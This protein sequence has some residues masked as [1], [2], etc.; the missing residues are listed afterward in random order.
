[1]NDSRILIVAHSPLASALLQCALHVF[2][3]CGQYVAAL[4]VQADEYPQ[5]SLDRA[6]QQLARLPVGE[7]ACVGHAAPLL[8]LTDLF[9]ATP[10]NVAH[11]L[12]ALSMAGVSAVRVIA[13]VNL[14]MLVR[15]ISYRH[16]PLADWVER[17]VSGGVNGVLALPET[18]VQATQFQQHHSHDPQQNHHHQ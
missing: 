4:D 6:L 10:S 8:V 14:P 16:E 3:D 15:A 2:P 9:G 1:M 18:S 11:R 7:A 12:A 13:G 5:E 17:A